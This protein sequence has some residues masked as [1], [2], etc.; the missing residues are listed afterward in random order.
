MKL[1]VI[2]YGIKP[3]NILQ[4]WIAHSNVKMTYIAENNVEVLPPFNNLLLKDP[5]ITRP[6]F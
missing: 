4:I 6:W 3:L 5:L 1:G 2:D